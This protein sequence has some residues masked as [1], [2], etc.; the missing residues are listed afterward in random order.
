MEHAFLSTGISRV[1]FLVCLG[2]CTS[3]SMVVDQSNCMQGGRCDLGECEATMIHLRI[4]F[5]V[6]H[7]SNLYLKENNLNFYVH[8]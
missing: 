8:G 4:S 2:A 3:D 5:E 7:V 1:S 6:V